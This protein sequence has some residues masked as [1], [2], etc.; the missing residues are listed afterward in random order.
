[1]SLLGARPIWIANWTQKY[2]I[3]GRYSLCILLITKLW[4][5]YFMNLPS[6]PVSLNS[7]VQLSWS[8]S[9]S[10]ANTRM[11]EVEKTSDITDSSVILNL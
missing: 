2:K 10:L 4:L 7:L 3:D 8:S 6:I 9:H 1:M 11:T 5:R